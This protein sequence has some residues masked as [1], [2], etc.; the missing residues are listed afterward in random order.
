LK[1]RWK[2]SVQGSAGCASSLVLAGPGGEP[3]L[4]HVEGQGASSQDLIVEAAH[5]ELRPQLLLRPIAQLEDLELA[6]FV[7]SAC[8]GA[9]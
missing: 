1:F 7:S 5:V 6:I 3:A 2:S 8:T 9:M 4:Q